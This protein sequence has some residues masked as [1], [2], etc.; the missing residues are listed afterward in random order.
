MGMIDDLNDQPN[1]EFY[2]KNDDI[3]GLLGPNQQNDAQRATFPNQ[4]TDMFD[5]HGR[6]SANSSGPL[7]FMNKQ[8][9]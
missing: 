9:Q 6:E 1:F 5:P 2:D 8:Y 4:M 3:M 7:S